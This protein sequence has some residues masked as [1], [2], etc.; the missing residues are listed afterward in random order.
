[1]TLPK[2]D[3]PID[4]LEWELFI[5]DRFRADRFDGNVID[6]ALMPMRS[7]FVPG[8]MAGGVAGGIVRGTPPP[9][10]FPASPAPLVPAANQLTGRV[11][12]SSGAALPGVT[13]V[14]TSGG[15]RQ[16]ATTDA[17]GFYVV[18][19]VQP[20]QVTVMGELQGF[21]NKRQTF[22]YSGEGRHVN[23]IL[24]V[25]STTETVAVSA[26]SPD[27]DVNQKTV[28]N[29]P[30]APSQ[31]VQNL[32]RR[33]SGVLPIRIEVPRAGVSYAFVKPLVVDEESVVTFRYKSR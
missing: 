1:M 7:G 3:V 2:M 22:R 27:V 19:G 8:G 23:L 33:A 15:Q 29:E 28:R 30:Q 16:L 5:P 14:V 11:L 26:E 31:N 21:K 18:S 12:D 32:Q 13:V 4:V 9:P 20:G 25:G 6:A 24:E 10:A 17:S